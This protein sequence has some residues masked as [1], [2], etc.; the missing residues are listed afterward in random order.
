MGQQNSYKDA[1]DH[2]SHDPLLC[3][4]TATG[5]QSTD[6]ASDAN[7]DSTSSTCMYD[8]AMCSFMLH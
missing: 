2:V 3:F 5:V 4:F 8:I 6:P 7:Q 1:F